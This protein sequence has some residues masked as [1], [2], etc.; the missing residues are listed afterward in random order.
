MSKL[1]FEK[2]GQENQDVEEINY[3]IKLYYYIIIFNLK[4]NLHHII[5]S[6]PKIKNCFIDQ[7]VL[8]TT[9]EEALS[10]DHG[11]LTLPQIQEYISEHHQGWT[12]EG[13]LGESNP[14]PQ[15]SRVFQRNVV[16]Y[17]WVPGE[18][19]TV[20]LGLRRIKKQN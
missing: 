15:H 1:N 14:T 18:C 19:V 13:F 3:K 10:V 2:I 12:L 16:R 6:C 11:Q 9:I 4:L 8:V 20:R 17:D 7:D 5:C